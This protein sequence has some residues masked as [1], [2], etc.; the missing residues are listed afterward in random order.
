MLSS[1]HL[2]LQCLGAISAS[3]PLP[4]NSNLFRT[5]RNFP[6]LCVTLGKTKMPLALS[7]LWDPRGC[8]P[9][10]LEPSHS[11]QTLRDSMQGPL[12]NLQPCVAPDFLLLL[13]DSLSHY[14]PPSLPLLPF[15]K[16][17]HCSIQK[18]QSLP[19]PLPSLLELLASRHF[20]SHFTILR[21]W[22]K[23]R[24]EGHCFSRLPITALEHVS[25][26]F[27]PS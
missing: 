11:F 20:L 21:G 7:D 1:T 26:T 22:G 24:E 25:S 19:N 10:C 5:T 9:I 3:H 12:L 2:T 18:H 27:S 13:A 15:S 14:Q 17:S 16:A 6:H 23:W 8:T 4:P